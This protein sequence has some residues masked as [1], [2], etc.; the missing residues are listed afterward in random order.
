MTKLEARIGFDDAPTTAIVVALGE[1]APQ[2]IVVV[3]EPAAHRPFHS[4][5][6]CLA[7]NAS[8]PA[9]ASSVSMLQV[10]VSLASSYAASSEASNCL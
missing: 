8:I 3:D 9:C 1:N 7:M 2:E 6:G 5:I 4:G 10:I